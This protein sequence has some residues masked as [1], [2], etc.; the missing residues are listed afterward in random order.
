LSVRFDHLIR[1]GK[2]ST[3]PFSPPSGWS[4]ISSVPSRPVHSEKPATGVS[5][6]A[7]RVTVVSAAPAG[8]PD[9]SRLTWKL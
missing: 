4:W 5:P 6:T 9:A 7:E 2:R 1:V 8:L 3:A